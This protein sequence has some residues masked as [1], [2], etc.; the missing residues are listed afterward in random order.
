MSKWF[1]ILFFGIIVFFSSVIVVQLVFGLPADR[2][3]FTIVFLTLIVAFGLIILNFRKFN[4]KVNSENIE[5]GYGIIKKK[6]SLNEVVSCEPTM[7]E[8]RVYGG[9]GIRLGVDG[10]LAYTTSFGNAVK[11]MR[12]NGVPFVFSTKNPEKLSKI[13]NKMSKS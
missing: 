11:I 3:A 7:A 2:P 10:S 4:I 9:V 6:I 8:G 5:V 13:I 12:R 1:F